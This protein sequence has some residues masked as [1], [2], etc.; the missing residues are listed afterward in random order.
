MVVRGDPYPVFYGETMSSHRDHP[1]RHE[2]DG[3]EKPEQSPRNDHDRSQPA[4]GSER[5]PWEPDPPTDPDRAF[6][7]NPVIDKD[8]GTNS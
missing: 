3:P 6:E 1:H 2:S 7:Q 8:H 5:H 4:G